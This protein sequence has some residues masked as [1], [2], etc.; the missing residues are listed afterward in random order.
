LCLDAGGTFS[1]CRVSGG[2]PF[3]PYDT[4][5][6]DWEL[7]SY[8]FSGPFE[9]QCT[10]SPEAWTYQLNPG[11]SMFNGGWMPSRLSAEEGGPVGS[12]VETLNDWCASTSSCSGSFVLDCSQPEG[13]RFSGYTV[14][15]S[16]LGPLANLLNSYD[17]SC[18]TGRSLGQFYES[19]YQD[20]YSDY[21][22][23]L[24]LHF[25]RF[26]DIN[27]LL[28]IPLNS[29]SGEL[30]YWDLLGVDD[31]VDLQPWYDA[32][33]AIPD[34][35]RTV[36]P[37]LDNSQIALFA[38]RWPWGDDLWQLA[39]DNGFSIASGGF[40]SA[41]RPA[42]HRRM[43]NVVYD[44]TSQQM[45]MTGATR[46]IGG[47][48]IDITP[49][50]PDDFDFGGDTEAYYRIFRMASL[51]AIAV[52]VDTIRL[53]G[54]AIPSNGAYEEV[55]CPGGQSCDFEWDALSGWDPFGLYTWMSRSVGRPLSQPVEAF[56]ALA[57]YGSSANPM[58]FGQQDIEAFE[59]ISTFAIETPIKGIGSYCRRLRVRNTGT[60]AR[61]LYDA[62]AQD[63][64]LQDIEH[65]MRA[66][67]EQV[68]EAT[69]TDSGSRDSVLYFDI[70]EDLSR[71]GYYVSDVR[72]EVVFAFAE[73]ETDDNSAFHIDYVHGIAA[74]SGV[75]TASSPQ[76]EVSTRDDE[77]VLTAR[78]DLERLYLTDRG[79]Y[80]ADLALVVDSGA[81]IDVLRLR[82][83]PN[84]EEPPFAIGWD[85]Q[86]RPD[87]SWE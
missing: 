6:V 87:W 69:S 29:E 3:Y 13:S 71:G 37:A 54:W 53:E 84:I 7:P 32:L 36:E 5:G 12:L 48:D 63:G 4:T 40:W 47:V 23:R 80:G 33:E 39:I 76:A 41:L 31:V 52:G 82:V 83:V 86:D 42:Y 79:R 25:L 74:R 64:A 28:N 55:F 62:D 75:F 19:A 30:Q 43:Q 27:Q 68:Y 70:D 77:V 78:F 66:L 11:G 8:A 14:D 57:S 85:I 18:S 65:N 21:L 16:L 35:L 26:A 38:P 67:G 56:C 73:G 22:Q 10:G 17:D 44:A 15:S 58:G 24:L 50:N 1:T 45:V 20:A 2:A 34:T 46:D 61:V 9:G 60:P 59:D 51:A 49:L 72:V 81:D